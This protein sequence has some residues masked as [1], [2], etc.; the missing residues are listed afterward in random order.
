[1]TQVQTGYAEF[2]DTKTYYE[3]GGNP[4]SKTLVFLPAAVADSGMYDGVFEAFAED[5]HVLRYDLRGTGKTEAPIPS[6]TPYSFVDDLHRL[7]A[8][9]KIDKAALIGTSNGGQVALDYALTYPEQV[10][11]LVLASSSL[12]G[13]EMQG[14][15]PPLL[16]ET[17]QAMQSGDF[18]KA[19]DLGVQLH[20]AGSDRKLEAIPEAT[21]QKTR[22]MIFQA[23]QRTGAG[24]GDNKPIDPS[25]AKRLGE[26]KVPTL[27]IID[28]HDHPA[29][30][31]MDQTIADGIPNAEAIK[32]NAGHLASIEMP[33][34]FTND[35]KVF[36]DRVL[37]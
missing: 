37:R 6:Q 14:E 32:L 13:Y 12:G 9:L 26:V 20:L 5:Y 25:A 10:E 29:V 18:E 1:M 2:N 4:N 21:R 31:A 24:L 28:E 3:M 27:V 15:P 7:L 36:L 34:E 16:M 35:V 33:D 11:A 8:Y 19:A 17:I 23:L 22:A 30:Q